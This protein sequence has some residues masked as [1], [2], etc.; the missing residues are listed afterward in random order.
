MG[1]GMGPQQQGNCM[2]RA[3][4]GIRLAGILFAVTMVAACVQRPAETAA[5]RTIQPMEAIDANASSAQAMARGAT[6]N[7]GSA[8]RVDDDGVHTVLALSAGGADGAY[9]AGVLNGWTRSGNRPHFDVVTGVSTGALMALLAFLGPD[10]D[11][12]LERFYTTQSNDKIYRKRG[13]D[14]IFGDSLYDN[15]PLKNQIEAFVTEDILRKVAAEHALGR[16]LYVATTNLDAGDLVIWDM[17]EI[18]QGT[19]SDSVLHFQKVLRASAAVPAYFPPV[20]IKPQRGIQLRQAHVDGGVKA[21]VLVAGF[22]FPERKMPKSLFMLINGNTTRLNASVPVKP[23]LSSI[24]QKS[25]TEMMR[26]LQ[27]ETVFRDF[28]ISRNVGATFRLTQIP[29]SIPLTTEGLNFDAARMRKLYEA[30]LADG[31]TGPA[32]WL[33]EPPGLGRYERLAAN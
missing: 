16:R 14:G 3:S 21:P 27:D 19:R 9:G 22:M 28:V 26:V 13:L 6:A 25:I 20:Y 8:P 4:S 1:Q 10:Y 2:G 12:E 30:G 17:G 5:I 11:S 18:A 23:T 24:A 32:G 7:E 33:K 31:M 15:G 29:D